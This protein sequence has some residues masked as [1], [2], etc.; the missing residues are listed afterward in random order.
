MLYRNP[1]DSDSRLTNTFLFNRA[2]VLGGLRLTALILLLTSKN[3]TYWL[4]LLGVYSSA[5]IGVGFLVAGLPCVPRA[6]SKVPLPKTIG[7]WFRSIMGSGER[8]TQRDVI[9]ASGGPGRRPRSRRRRGLWEITELEETELRSQD[10]MESPL[11]ETLHAEF[12]GSGHREYSPRKANDDQ[13]DLT[14]KTTE[15]V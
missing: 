15:M 4:S 13:S 1:T 6:F 5:E 2:T 10:V 12:A 8:G 14:A 11:D 9:A 3:Q 7:Y